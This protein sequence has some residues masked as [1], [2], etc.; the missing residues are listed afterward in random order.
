MTHFNEPYLAP[1]YGQISYQTQRCVTPGIFPQPMNL[2]QEFEWR[3]KSEPD[4]YTSLF[5]FYVA[6]LAIPCGEVVDTD[7]VDD[8]DSVWAALRIPMRLHDGRSS[9]ILID[10]LFNCYLATDSGNDLDSMCARVNS[11]FLLLCVHAR[12]LDVICCLVVDYLTY[13]GGMEFGHNTLG[14]NL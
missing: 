6:W 10:F 7:S 8:L 2:I 4:T 5:R 14:F 9:E 3:N 11:G 1:F 12:Y 13:M